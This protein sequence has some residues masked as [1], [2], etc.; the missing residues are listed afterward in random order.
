MATVAATSWVFYVTAL[1]DLL[2]L[3]VALALS[4][5]A[6]INCLLQRADAFPAIGTLSKSAWLALI[7]VTFVLALLLSYGGG[8]LGLFSLIA[9]AVA[10][11]YLL[12]VRPAVRDVSGGR[13]PW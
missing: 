10:L 3:L 7:G 12:D 4:L 6:F 5:G 11:V 13:G 1:I 9:L 2:L 8:G